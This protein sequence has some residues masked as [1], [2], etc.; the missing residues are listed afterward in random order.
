VAEESLFQNP[1][2]NILARTRIRLALT[3]TPK[4]LF[5]GSFAFG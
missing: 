4:L 5:S 2:L 3:M 1:K